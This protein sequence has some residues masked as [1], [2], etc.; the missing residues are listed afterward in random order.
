[1]NAKTY[2]YGVPALCDFGDCYV[3]VWIP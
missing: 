3:I 1:M 2:I